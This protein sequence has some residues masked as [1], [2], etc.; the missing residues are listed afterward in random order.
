MLTQLLIR[1]DPEKVFINVK[2]AEA[3]SITTGMGVALCGGLV[4]AA[5]SADGVNALNVG[6]AAGLMPSFIGVARGDIAANTYGLVQ[7]W[8]FAASILLSQE[9]DKTIGCQTVA[10]LIFPKTAHLLGSFTST[11]LPEAISTYCGKYVVNYLT[12]NISSSLPYTSGF[13]RCM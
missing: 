9:T 12:T 13:V 7:C 5:A 8:G 3:S 4:G 2:N 11:L 10:S 6:T 1:T